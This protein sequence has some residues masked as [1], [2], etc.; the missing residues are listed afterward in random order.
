M[1]N[2]LRVFN[3]VEE[4]NEDFQTYAATADTCNIRKMSATKGDTKTLWMICNDD[5]EIRMNIAGLCFNRITCDLRTP[6]P[7]M[8]YMMSRIRSYEGPIDAMR[9]FYKRIWHD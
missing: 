6:Q 8:M 4:M 5:K 2:H 1:I 9:V 7:E 3:N